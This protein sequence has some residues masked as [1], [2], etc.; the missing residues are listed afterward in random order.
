MSLRGPQARTPGWPLLPFGHD[1]FYT[2]LSYGWSGRV[3]K[4]ALQG[5]A[6]LKNDLMTET[7]L[8]LLLNDKLDDPM[9]PK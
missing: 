6:G 7:V 1:S 2:I 4:K 9:L 8:G 5:E 3:V